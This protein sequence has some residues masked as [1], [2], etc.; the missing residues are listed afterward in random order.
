[1]LD[2]HPE[3]KP[4]F[5]KEKG[6]QK[7]YK[8]RAHI[9][10]HSIDEGLTRLPF[11]NDF[12]T[13]LKEKGDTSLIA[14]NNSDFTALLVKFAGFLAIFAH[15]SQE[16]LEVILAVLVASTCIIFRSLIRVPLVT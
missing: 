14:S 12:A 3:L 13:Y 5:E 10:A 7:G 15:L 6:L 11:F 16:N 4:N 1:M 2:L 9:T 8:Y